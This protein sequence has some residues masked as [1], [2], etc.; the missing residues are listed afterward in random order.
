MHVASEVSFWLLPYIPEHLIKE[1]QT[2]MATAMVMQGQFVW[3]RPL[4]QYQAL[5]HK[6]GYMCHAASTTVL[7]LNVHDVFV[8]SGNQEFDH[9]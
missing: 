4:W 2:V 7:L 6:Q 1:K 9:V 8:N 5:S 3:V